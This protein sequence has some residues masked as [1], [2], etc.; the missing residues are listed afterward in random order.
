MQLLSK[1]KQQD[2]DLL[3]GNQL[4]TKH[5]ILYIRL[6]LQWVTYPRWPILDF[7]QIEWQ[8]IDT[9]SILLENGVLSNIQSH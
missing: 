5:N 3:F 9:S 4:A 8:I 2:V 1:V 7:Y 6:L